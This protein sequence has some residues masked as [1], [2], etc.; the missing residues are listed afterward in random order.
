MTQI[1]Q[2]WQRQ[3]GTLKIPSFTCLLWEI[4]FADKFGDGDVSIQGFQGFVYCCG[5]K[6]CSLMA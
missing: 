4:P 6:F 2:R 1:R 5:G 3:D